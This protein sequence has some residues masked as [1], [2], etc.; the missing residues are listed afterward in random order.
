MKA[1]AA[2]P[3]RVLPSRAKLALLLAQKDDAEL[4]GFVADLQA[5]VAALVNLPIREAAVVKPVTA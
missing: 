4:P 2:A 1:A 3:L 5:A